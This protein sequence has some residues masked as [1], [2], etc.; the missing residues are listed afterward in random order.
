MKIGILTCGH[1]DS[2]L[3]D[4]HGQ[5]ADMIEA[6]LYEVNNEFTFQNY[7][8]TKGELPHH[9]EC[10]G[11]IITGSVNN[12]YDDHPWILQLVDW[13]IRC[14][15]LRRPLVG[16]C[17]GHQ[18]IARALGGTV[19]KSEKGWGLGSYEVKVTAQKK[20]M[21]LSV[22]SA[23]LL[24]S[25]QDQVTTV[26][27]GVKVIASNEFCPNF[28]L[29]KD[30]HVLTVQG[31]PEFGVSFTEKLVEKRKHLITP[32]YYQ[33]AFIELSQPQDSALILHW[34]DNFF[35]MAKHDKAIEHRTNPM[36]IL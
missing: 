12:A 29:V 32:Q 21:N 10:H 20:W 4:D 28:M 11:F 17:F 8:A 3:S 23:R 16:I 6:S 36:E 15:V 13:I 31:H 18:L 5:Y 22:D 2:P 1:V 35:V 25:H 26:P 9:D 34:I 30:N 24:V 33:Q 7:D 27:R 14:E 19:Q